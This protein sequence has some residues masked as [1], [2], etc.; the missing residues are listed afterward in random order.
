MRALFFAL[1]LVLLVN[2]RSIDLYERTVDVPKHAWKSDFTPQFDFE[3]K[4]T[5]ALYEASLVL[6]HTDGYR[7]NNI[8]LEVQVETPDSLYSFRTEKKLGD[9]EK[10]WLGT[11][12]NDV[13]EHRISLNPELASAG[14]SFRKS[15][16]YTFRLTQLMRED[17]LPNI[18]QAGIRIERKR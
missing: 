13:F 12:L 17:P 2:C 18:L 11:G 3:I 14:I 1:I 4:D 9:N 16:T 7:F 10:G 15:G 6:R 5:L 8:W